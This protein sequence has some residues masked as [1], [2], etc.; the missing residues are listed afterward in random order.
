MPFFMSVI[1]AGD[2]DGFI[3]KFL[4]GPIEEEGREVMLESVD[5]ARV[6]GLWTYRTPNRENVLRYLI[7]RKLNL[8]RVHA[9]A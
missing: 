7:I 4:Y 3:G 8:S 1:I 6:N 5:G 2:N 9:I